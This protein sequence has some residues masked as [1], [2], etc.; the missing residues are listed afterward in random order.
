MGCTRTLMFRKMSGSMDTKRADGP[1]PVGPS[2]EGGDLP[3]LPCTASVMLRLDDRRDY[4]QSRESKIVLEI[5]AKN[6][7]FMK[8]TRS[9]RG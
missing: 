6:A 5:D 4:W 7:E 2:G 1:G 3:V 8:A 9:Q